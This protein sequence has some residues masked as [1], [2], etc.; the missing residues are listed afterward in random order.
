[1][2]TIVTI[3][4]STFRCECVVIAKLFGYGTVHEYKLEKHFCDAKGA[5]FFAAPREL[6]ISGAS[7]SVDRRVVKRGDRY[8]VYM[9]W[10]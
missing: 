5:Q 2:T 6:C 7:R 9:E 4:P 10:R 1:M 8:N 3:F